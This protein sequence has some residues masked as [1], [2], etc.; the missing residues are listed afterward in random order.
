MQNSVEASRSAVAEARAAGDAQLLA[1]DLLR[2]ADVA[3]RA[4]HWADASAAVDEATDLHHTHG[5]PI[6]EARCLRLAATLQRLQGHPDVAKVRA[7]AALHLTQSD[8]GRDMDVRATY[9]ELG[10]IALAQSDP[11]AALDAFDR[12]L[13]DGV[14]APPAWSRGRAKAHALAGDFDAAAGDLEAA[15]RTLEAGGETANALRATVEAAT[16]WQQSRRFDRAQALVDA[17]RPRALAAGDQEALAGLALLSAT[18]AL[19]QHDG[20]AAR[21]FALAARGH[22]LAS[23]GATAY[24]GAAVALSRIDELAGNLVDAYAALATGWATTGDLI[25]AD[26]ARAAFAP[27]LRGLRDRCGAAAFFEARKS[28]ERSVQERKHKST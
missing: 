2:H 14:G 16:A 22:A 7:Q 17:A 18:Q 3:L 21:G 6:E 1:N 20:P 4:G 25:G 9:A 24:I 5:S 28:Y 13:A 19:E 26:L 11:Q 8:M 15:A 12:A 10:E 23:R 27:L